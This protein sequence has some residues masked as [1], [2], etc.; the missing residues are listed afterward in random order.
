VISINNQLRKG[1]WLQRSFTL[2]TLNCFSQGN[3]KN[4][5]DTVFRS[6]GAH[7]APDDAPPTAK[8]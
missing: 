2:S 3:Y 7:L 6:I 1:A 5:S 8:N 4:A